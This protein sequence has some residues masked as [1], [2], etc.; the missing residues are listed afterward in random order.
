MAVPVHVS[1]D[2][3]VTP[4]AGEIT[5]EVSTGAVL[6]TVMLAESVSVA[7]PVSVAVAR[8]VTVSVGAT[9]L[10]VRVSVVPVPKTPPELFCHS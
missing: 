2:V 5:T 6:S 3:V 1:V 7:E 10:G 4:V 8:H 9:M